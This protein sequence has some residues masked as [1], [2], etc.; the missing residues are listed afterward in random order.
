MQV[1]PQRASRLRPRVGRL[2]LHRAT[3]RCPQDELGAAILAPGV[4]EILIHAERR[5]RVD[6]RVDGEEGPVVSGI[7]D[8]VT[9]RV[10][11][12]DWYP[13]DVR[14]LKLDERT[15]LAMDVWP[16]TA[17]PPAR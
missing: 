15:N 14:V 2:K 3:A 5:T 1:R 11:T 17:N 16:S 13:C 7:R 4:F 10:A 8:A 12:L 9:F 6:A